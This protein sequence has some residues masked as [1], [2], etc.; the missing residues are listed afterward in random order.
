[1]SCPKHHLHGEFHPILVSAKGP[2]SD[3]SGTP[4]RT[5][6]FELNKA[7]VIFFLEKKTG[8]KNV[9][10]NHVFS[11]TSGWIDNF[12]ILGEGTKSC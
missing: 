9:V 10:S 8:C 3:V 5:A 7:V 6:V 2:D 12:S 11:P 4:E 1:M